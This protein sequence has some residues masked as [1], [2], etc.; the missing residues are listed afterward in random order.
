MIWLCLA[1]EAAAICGIA[2]GAII[3][4]IAKRKAE[5]ATWE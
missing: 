4:Q 1:F 5:A 2:V 3:I